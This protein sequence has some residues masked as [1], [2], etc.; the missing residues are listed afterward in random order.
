MF[1]IIFFF[2][3]LSNNKK[4]SECLPVKSGIVMDLDE[5]TDRG[6]DSQTGKTSESTPQVCFH[7]FFFFLYRNVSL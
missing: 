2:K 7:D 1:K 6:E 3:G 5:E 4:D